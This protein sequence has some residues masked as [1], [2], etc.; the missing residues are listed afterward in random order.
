[1][2][3]ASISVLLDT[4]VSLNA[5]LAQIDGA[6]TQTLL[7]YI[8]DPHVSNI[9]L[10]DT[11]MSKPYL[12]DTV[13]KAYFNR[14]DITKSYARPVHVK[15]APVNSAVWDVILGRSYSGADMDTMTAHQAL[16]RLS[17]RNEAQGLW[18]LRKNDLAYEIAHKVRW[19]LDSAYTDTYTRDSIAALIRLQDEGDVHK[20]LIELDVQFGEYD[21]ALAKINTYTS[22]TSPRPMLDYANFMT[23][24]ISLLQDTANIFGLRYN[25]TMTSDFYAV[26][27]SSGHPCRQI[28]RNVLDFV[29]NSYYEIQKLMPESGTGG[30]KAQP[31]QQTSK[32]ANKNSNEILVYPNPASNEIFIEN[33]T[34][35]NPML[36]IYNVSGQLL[37]QQKLGSGKQTVDTGTLLNGIYFVNLYDKNG[38]SKTKKLVIVK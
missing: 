15:N 14:S 10:E 2:H 5:Q 33:Y 23:Q 12:S 3:T 1:V 13:M 11:L 32:L 17:P 30:R 29:Y 22:T 8:A 31:G 26:A 38:I 37:V 19:F 7:A 28:A 6:E 21:S 27:D 36:R 9:S 16:G 25:T 18:V 20:R 4:L 34:G 24:Y 35:E